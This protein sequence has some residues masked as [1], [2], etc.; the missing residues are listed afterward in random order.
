M[1]LSINDFRCFHKISGIPLRPIN[2]LVGENSSGKTSLLAALRFILDLFGREGK[3]SFNKDPFYLGS[4]EQIAH[5][6]GGRFGRAKHFSFRLDGQF[7]NAMGLRAVRSTAEKLHSTVPTAFDLC[8]GFINHRSEPAVSD[9]EFSCGEYAV[10]AEFSEEISIKIKTPTIQEYEFSDRFITRS[11]DSL[12]VN[13]SYIEF[14]LR[15][16]RFMEADKEEKPPELFYDEVALLGELYR[17][18]RRSLPLNVYA[19]APVRSKPERTYNPGE[20][21]PAPSGEHIPFVLAQIKAFDKELWTKVEKTLQTFGAASGLFEDVNIRRLSNT[22]GGPFQLIVGLSGA[23]S[24][25]M[26]VGYGVSQALPI[27]TDLVR[28][29][30]KTLFLL[31]QPEVHLHPRAQAELATLFAQI[32]KEKSHTL[33]V[34]THSDYLIDRMR[35]E[36][37]DGKYIKPEDVSILFFERSGLD[38]VVHPISIDG[39][40]NIRGA[41]ATYRDFF[42]REEF[43]SLGM[44]FQ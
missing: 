7:S 16:L 28:A 2:I 29:Q 35:M 37:R 19:S 31:Q 25:I 26:D 27:I 1:N 44:E 30:Q 9:I 23:K 13:F 4:Y 5:Y 39:L 42:I 6:R 8:I 32:V 22:E 12:L 20:A 11:A 43:R 33:F 17:I 14:I 21:N 3:A 38:I 18:A 40:G 41:P 36:A 34:E 15:D 10:R 24:N